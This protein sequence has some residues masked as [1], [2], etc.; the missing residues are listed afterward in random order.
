MMQPEH[1]SLEQLLL[2]F[3]RE[4]YMTDPQID[5]DSAQQLAN[6]TVKSF[7]NWLSLARIATSSARQVLN[8]TPQP[9]PSFNPFAFS[10][11]AT[12]LEFGRGELMLRLEQIGSADQLR[13][14]AAAQHLSIDPHLT[15]TA[16]LR[17]AIAESAER[18][19]SN[20]K[21]AARLV[22]TKSGVL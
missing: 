10:A 19:L 13:M 1:G 15:Q 12:L 9:P 3:L 16:D 4:V 8:D 17:L 21:S 18:R 6:L 14:F 22:K 7:G 11:V 5:E 2:S 20:R